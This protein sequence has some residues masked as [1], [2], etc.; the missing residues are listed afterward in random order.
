MII[1]RSRTISG[2]P[3][4]LL[5]IFLFFVTI[6][7]YT[8]ILF[9]FFFSLRSSSTSSWIFCSPFSSPFCFLPLRLDIVNGRPGGCIRYA[10]M[11]LPPGSTRLAES[12]FRFHFVMFFFF[13]EGFCFV[14]RL[15]NYPP[16]PSHYTCT[17]V[18][19]VSR[20]PD[21]D[22]GKDTRQKLG[23]VEVE[24]EWTHDGCKEQIELR[25]RWV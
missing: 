20:M 19:E 6:F 15:F 1:I 4:S 21:P 18:V 13:L 9:P 7:H 16:L 3:A 24:I 5:I 12:F 23:G 14:Y 8:F 22:L 11:T 2:F 10:S 25:R 17:F